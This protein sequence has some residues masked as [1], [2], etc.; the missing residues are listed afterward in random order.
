MLYMAQQKQD[1]ER[2]QLGDLTNKSGD[3]GKQVPAAELPF[4]EI[5]V[6]GSVRL[7]AAGDRLVWDPSVWRYAKP[8]PEMLD[9]FVELWREPGSASA[10]LIYAK[11]WG[12][13]YLDHGGRPCNKFIGREPGKQFLPRLEP[14]ESWR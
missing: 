4:G 9:A 13:L 14:L 8:L 7:D 10:I 5:R 6:P 12:P 1:R 2:W 3:V 11:K